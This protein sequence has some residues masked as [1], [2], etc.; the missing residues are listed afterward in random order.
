MTCRPSALAERLPRERARSFVGPC[1]PAS[2]HQFEVVSARRTAW[3]LMLGLCCALSRP[4]RGREEPGEDCGGLL[5]LPRLPLNL[6]PARFRE[7]VELGF[8]IVFRHAPLGGDV[9]FLFEFQERGIES[10]V[11]N[12]Q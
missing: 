1:R 9:P 4:L 7:P 2:G 12:R 8:A 3:I 6:L 11:V 5:P 10:P